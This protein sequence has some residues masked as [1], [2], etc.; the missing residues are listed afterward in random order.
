[1]FLDELRTPSPHVGEVVVVLPFIWFSQLRLSPEELLK[2][3]ED[4]GIP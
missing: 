2:F 4:T 3:P 1:M